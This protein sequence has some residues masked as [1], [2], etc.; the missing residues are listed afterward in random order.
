MYNN[1]EIEIAKSWYVLAQISIILAGFMFASAGIYYNNSISLFSD[2]VDIVKDTVDFVNF[3]STNQELINN[4]SNPELK[5]ILNISQDYYVDTSNI[6]KDLTL[7]Q[8]SAYGRFN[9]LGVFFV[10][11]SVLFWGIGKIKL[12]KIKF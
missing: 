8:L 6:Y 9:Q 1:I 11:M 4:N 10:I 5:G 2:Q 3:V 12:G 7:S